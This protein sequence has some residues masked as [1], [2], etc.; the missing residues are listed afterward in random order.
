VLVVVAGVAATSCAMALPVSSRYQSVLIER[1]LDSA[2]DEDE[3]GVDA[4]CTIKGHLQ[5]LGGDGEDKSKVVLALDAA[6]ARLEARFGKNVCDLEEVYELGDFP[7]QSEDEDDEFFLVR[8][9]HPGT[10][11]TA[12]ASAP[13]S[14]IESR[15]SLF[16]LASIG[17]LLFASTFLGVAHCRKRT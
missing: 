15:H 8:K 4:L 5:Y 3:D 12:S 1:L 13:L 10:T 16:T 14:S 6:M 17:T 9:S 7:A 11:T 2:L